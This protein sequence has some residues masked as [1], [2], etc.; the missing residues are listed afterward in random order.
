MGIELIGYMRCKEG[1]NLNLHS[2]EH[3]WVALLELKRALYFLECVDKKHLHGPLVLVG[4]FHRPN[5]VAQICAK[6]YRCKRIYFEGFIF[7]IFLN[8]L[9]KFDKLLKPDW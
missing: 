9:L 3:V 8:C 2:Y 1:F 4:V 6:T 5:G 7:M